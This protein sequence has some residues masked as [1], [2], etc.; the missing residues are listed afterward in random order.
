MYQPRYVLCSDSFPSP[1]SF[2]KESE[3]SRL[4]G[5]DGCSSQNSVLMNDRAA[6]FARSILCSS[7]TVTMM[8]SLMKPSIDASAAVLSISKGYAIAR[9]LAD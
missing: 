9:W 1:A 7:L 8:M 3:S 2:L 4:R 5:S 6:L